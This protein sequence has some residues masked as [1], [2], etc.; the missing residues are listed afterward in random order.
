MKKFPGKRKGNNLD[1]LDTSVPIAAYAD[2]FIYNSPLLQN[3]D[4]I[5]LFAAS[6]KVRHAKR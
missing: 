4:S 3:I 6:D 2:L 5:C 1:V